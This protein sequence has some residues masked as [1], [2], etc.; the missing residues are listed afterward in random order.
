MNVIKKEWYV[1]IYNIYVCVYICV[2]MCIYV[3]IYIC[4]YIY[5][6]ILFLLFKKNKIMPFVASNM[7]RPT[8]YHTK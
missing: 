6:G 3:Y 4:I 1:Y 5:N 8:D 2:C 7:D